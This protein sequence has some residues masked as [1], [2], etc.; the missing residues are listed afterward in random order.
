MTLLLSP[1]GWKMHQA[2]QR[3]GLYFYSPPITRIGKRVQEAAPWFL[4]PI[5][6]RP[7]I[8]GQDQLSP[9]HWGKC[10]LLSSWTDWLCWTCLPSRAKS[11][12]SCVALGIRKECKL[13]SIPFI[14]QSR[15]SHMIQHCSRE[16]L[17]GLGQTIICNSDA[18]AGHSL[19][20]IHTYLHK[21]GQS[22]SRS[23][24]SSIP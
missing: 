5:Q 23:M 16:V 3:G 1:R 2:K 15:I 21:S 4:P 10:V 17:F 11:P 20:C 19:G 24:W 9:E 14:A 7:G 18:L 12:V 13:L 22:R 6:E 8:G